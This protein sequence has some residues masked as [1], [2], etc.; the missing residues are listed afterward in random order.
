MKFRKML[1]AMAEQVWATA[2][3]ELMDSRYAR[4]TPNRAARNERKLLELQESER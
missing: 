2:A 4:Q 1:A 3:R